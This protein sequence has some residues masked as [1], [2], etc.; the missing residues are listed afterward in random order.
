LSSKHSASIV[1]N[2][3]EDGGYDTESEDIDVGDSNRL[4]T[5]VVEKTNDQEEG[6]E[7]RPGFQVF[8]SFIEVE[9][10]LIH[11]R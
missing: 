11:Q 2:E 1:W 9:S 6:A 8:L 3:E 10:V 5:F 7:S 4:V